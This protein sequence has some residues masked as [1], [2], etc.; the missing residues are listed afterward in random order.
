MEAIPGQIHVVP[1]GLWQG[2]EQEAECSEKWRTTGKPLQWSF[3]RGDGGP[4]TNIY[5]ICQ[6]LGI[7][8]LSSYP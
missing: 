4:F 5:S 1:Q 7:P 3:I 2:M 8:S 6:V